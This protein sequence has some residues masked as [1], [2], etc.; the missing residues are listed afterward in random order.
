[1]I[2]TTIQGDTPQQLAFVERF[3]DNLKTTLS[4][5][6][7]R[8]ECVQLYLWQEL[9]P[10]GP[11]DYLVTGNFQYHIGNV[12]LSSKIDAAS[13]GEMMR[14]EDLVPGRIYR[15]RTGDLATFSRIGATGLAIFHPPGESDMQ[16][17]FAI[18]PEDV[19]WEMYPW[20]ANESFMKHLHL[21]DDELLAMAIEFNLGPEPILNGKT[22]WWKD[23]PDETR[24]HSIV[25]RNTGSP[26][27]SQPDRWAIMRNE[28]WCLNKE[29]Q[30]EYQPMPSSR[31]EDFYARCRYTSV[32][33]A[34]GYYERWKQ[35]ILT[36]AALQLNH[37]PKAV[38]RYEDAPAVKFEEKS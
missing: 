32:R 20:Q 15:M 1:M 23:Y 18:A 27:P 17:S 9:R 6:L 33:E 21:P 24:T 16:S 11:D 8:G 3:C 34:I 30:W 37:D 14:I 26:D 25:A 10:H 13:E 19:S 12:E 35:S 28:C 29:G 2:A 22:F 31:R 7:K 4:N 36:W 38:L 5:S